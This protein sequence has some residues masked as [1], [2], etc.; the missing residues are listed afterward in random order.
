M[1]S[2]RTIIATQT[3][4]RTAYLTWFGVR[5]TSTGDQ[6]SIFFFR[7]RRKKITRSSLFFSLFTRKE[8][9]AQ[10]AIEMQKEEAGNLMM[11]QKSSREVGDKQEEE[12]RKSPLLC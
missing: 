10:D 1:N 8:K 2:L 11:A 12:V 6:W 4:Q 5:P 7:Q 9:V 3:A